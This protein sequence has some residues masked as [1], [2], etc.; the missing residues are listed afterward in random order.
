MHF[1]HLCQIWAFCYTRKCVLVFHPLH[2][3]TSI[4]N[5]GLHTHLISVTHT[6]TYTYVIYTYTFVYYV[7][8]YTG[9]ARRISYFCMNIMLVDQLDDGFSFFFFFFAFAINFI[10]FRFVSIL[11]QLLFIN[12]FY[13]L[14]YIFCND[15]FGIQTL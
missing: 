1:L 3:T 7:R 5:F 15:M 2:S 13:Y 9:H 6:Y 8:F 10:S 12:I 4:F 11:V 14:L